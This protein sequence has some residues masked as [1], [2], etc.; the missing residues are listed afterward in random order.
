ML[1][2]P[3]NAVVTSAVNTSEIVVTSLLDGI[4]QTSPTPH[5]HHMITINKAKSVVLPHLSLVASKR[6]HEGTKSINKALKSPYWF[7]VMQDEINILHSNKT[8]ILVSKYA[9]INLVGSK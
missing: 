8:W 7:I 4:A 6:N 2:Q 9:G 1:N 3:I 5:K